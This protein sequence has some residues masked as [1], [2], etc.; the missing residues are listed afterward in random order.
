[1][2]RLIR[3]FF[4]LF[5]RGKEYGKPVFIQ[6]AE[7]GG[8]SAHY[9]NYPETFGQGENKKEALKS[10]NKTLDAVLRIEAAEAA[11][12]SNLVNNDKAKQD[13]KRRLQHV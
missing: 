1:M 13:G 10:L 7:S 6:D 5:S 8:Y 9:E 4:K 11:E 12:I 3:N 2:L